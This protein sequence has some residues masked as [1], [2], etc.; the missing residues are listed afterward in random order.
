MTE[1]RLKTFKLIAVNMFVSLLLFNPTT[2]AQSIT[3]TAPSAETRIAEGRDYAT[4]ELANRWDMTCPDWIGAPNFPGDPIWDAFFTCDL[5]VSKSRCVT[6]EIFTSGIYAAR[7]TNTCNNANVPDANLIFVSPGPVAGVELSNGRIYPIDTSTYRHF[8][9]KVRTTNTGSNQPGMVFFQTSADASDPIGRAGFKTIAPGDW[10]IITF[11]MINDINIGGNAT[12]TWDG[13]DTVIGFRLDPTPN[14][15]INFEIDWARLTTDADSPMAP[16]SSLLVEWTASGIGGGSTFTITAIDDDGAEFVLAESLGSA[17][18]SAIVDL[19]KLAPGAYAIEVSSGGTSDQSGFHALVNHAPELHITQPDKL[20]DESRDFASDVL[21]NPWGPM[22]T[23]DI[24]TDNDGQTNLQNILFDNGELLADAPDAGLNPGDPRMT[25]EM[26]ETL[27]SDFYRMLS[28]EFELEGEPG[29]TG[30]VARIH[31]GT[32]PKPIPIPDT[33]SDDI[34]V[35]AGMNTYVVGDMHEVPD[36][37][38]FINQWQGQITNLRFDPHEVNDTR[39]IV[40]RSMRIRPFDTSTGNYLIEWDL[41]DENSP[42][43]TL[44]LNLYFDEDRNPDNANDTLII[45]NLDVSN[46]LSNY[47]WNTDGLPED[48]VEIRAEVSDG[49]NTVSRYAS[50]PLSIIDSLIFTDGFELF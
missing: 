1:I 25:F 47:L 36:K 19:S 17:V 35:R 26:S 48:V 44:L 41:I 2:R 8:T 7:S 50:G 6:N 27:D 43:D 9:V 5:V 32:D 40:F 13:Q 14:N 11:D 38:G 20:G 3:V 49:F 4:Y 42:N 29:Q 15:N 12:L 18:R 33:V 28:Y 45:G 46:G 39:F 22:D 24:I 34:R 37:D 31:W 10:Q 16:D 23:A 21:G 30:S